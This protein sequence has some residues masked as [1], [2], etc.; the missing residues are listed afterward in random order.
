[1]GKGGVTSLNYP[2]GL[3][4]VGALTGNQSFTQEL[5]EFCFGRRFCR[6]QMR[7]TNVSVTCA[8]RREPPGQPPMT[9]HAAVKGGGRRF[10]IG[11]SEQPPS[12][13]PWF[14]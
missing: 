3:P 2:K 6:Y 7:V 5:G 11:A 12:F 14:R 1:M 13:N 8:C 10:A 9:P 4:S